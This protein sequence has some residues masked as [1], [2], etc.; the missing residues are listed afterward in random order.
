MTLKDGGFPFA[1]R[2]IACVASLAFPF[3]LVKIGVLVPWTNAL[4]KIPL[5]QTHPAI[6]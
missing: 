5:P 4:I 1:L 3:K 2:Q 6:C